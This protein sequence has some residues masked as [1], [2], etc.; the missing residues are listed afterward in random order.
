VDF[1]IATWIIVAKKTAAVGGKQS[2]I[3]GKLSHNDRCLA[4][5]IVILRADGR[6]DI[7]YGHNNEFEKLT[8]EAVV[9]HFVWTHLAVVVVEQKKMKVFINGIHS[10]LSSQRTPRRATGAP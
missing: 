1:S 10:R 3:T 2:F 5:T 6:L 9:P 8:T 4:D 7:L